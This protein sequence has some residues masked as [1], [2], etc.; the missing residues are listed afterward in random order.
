MLQYVTGKNGEKLLLFYDSG[1]VEAT[2][3]D[4]GFSLMD[5][6]P[7]RAG[8][9]PLDVAGGQTIQNPYG[10]EI[11]KLK[12]TDGSLVEVT[13]LRMPEITTE[14]P[15]WELT[16]SWN[17]VAK[18]YLESGGLQADVPSC[19]ANIGGC[20]VDMMLGVE[21]MSCFP[22]LI[23]EMPGGLRLYRSRLEAADGHLGIL[24]GPSKAWAHASAAAHVMG[25]KVFFT[26]E[27]R[28]MQSMNITLKSCLKPEMPGVCK[29]VEPREKRIVVRLWKG[30]QRYLY[31]VGRI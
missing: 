12:K 30:I 1:C 20:S 26:A 3:S 4:R 8:P 18:S 19:P 11:F 25:P 21:Y 16:E 29:T 24:G 17:Q 22:D 14:L 10:Y 2:V 13:S 15:M 27:A 28:A 6:R 9:V 7:G 5:T 23:F 31:G